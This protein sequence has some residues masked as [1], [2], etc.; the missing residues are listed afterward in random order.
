MPSTHASSAW[1]D[2]ATSPSSGVVSWSEPVVGVTASSSDD[3]EP[4]EQPEQLLPF[5]GVDQP[6][7]QMTDVQ[8]WVP[9]VDAAT[10]ADE[11]DTPVSV[12]FT[13]SHP[14]GLTISDPVDR[15]VDD[16]DRDRIDRS[17]VN[18]AISSILVKNSRWTG[19]I[20]VITAL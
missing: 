19:L 11:V 8:V 18:R 17:N 1:A 3:P 20:L 4:M 9:V 7:N 14:V 13:I 16:I 10:I 2:G 5:T 12:G 6:L 15:P